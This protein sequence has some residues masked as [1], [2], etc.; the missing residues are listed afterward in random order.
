V[1]AERIAQDLALPTAFIHSLARTASY[2]YKTYQIPKRTG[3]MR[4]IHHPSRR[5]KALQ[6]WL[7]TNVIERLPIH[8]AA[9]GYRIGR[10][11][12]DNARRHIGSNYLLRLDFSN[13]FESI[14]STDLR[15]YIA[16]RAHLFPGW[17]SSDIEFF[18]SIVCR[19]ATLTIGAPTSPALSNV[20]CFDLD[21]AI[22]NYCQVR[23]IGYTRYADDL[24]FSTRT[25]N[26]LNNLEGEVSRI[27]RD[28]RFPVSLRLNP[29]KVRHSSK[30]GARRVTGV[31]LGSDGRAYVGRRLKRKIRAQIHHL[32]RLS[33][34]ERSSLAGLIAY[35]IGNDPGFMNSLINK[36]GLERVREA[37][38]LAS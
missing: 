15:A 25:P 8:D 3:G 22:Q 14:R 38:Q 32:E 23:D 19:N 27:C 4:I 12:I 13:F 2:E 31:V 18:C 36:Y 17:L 30:R 33:P 5:L 34:T 16:D 26:V 35:V 10:S 28:L 29:S 6:R 7:L 9:M 11:T 24:F 1:I 37:R 20:V 21:Q